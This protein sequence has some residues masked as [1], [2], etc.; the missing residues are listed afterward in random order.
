MEY[1]YQKITPFLMFSGQA[2]EA[3]N[4]YVSAFES[5]EIISIT[6]YGANE[7]GEEGS[8]LHAAFSLMGQVFM[9]IDSNVQHKFTFTPSMSLSVICDTEEEIDRIFT[10]LSE[11]G[12]VLMPLGVYPFSKKFSWIQDKYG[13]SWQ[14]NLA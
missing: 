11:G 7:T 2:E 4:F 8:V 12:A 13:V 1:P 6:R 14:L 5:S 3:M 9:C 10:R